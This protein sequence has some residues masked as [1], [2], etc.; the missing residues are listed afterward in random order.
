MSKFNKDE[1]FCS[2][3]LIHDT[4]FKGGGSWAS[5]SCPECGGTACTLYQSLTFVQKVKARKKFDIMWKIKWNI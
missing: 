1:L 2:K 4:F 3:C 5:S